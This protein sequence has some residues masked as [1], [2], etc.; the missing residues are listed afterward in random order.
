M[1]KITA[2]K[3]AY[4]V[5]VGH[6]AWKNMS[7]VPLYCAKNMDMNQVLSGSQ[8]LTRNSLFIVLLYIFPQEKRDIGFLANKK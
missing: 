1:C 3:Q 8:W 4:Y 6:L 7:K 5:S 2:R